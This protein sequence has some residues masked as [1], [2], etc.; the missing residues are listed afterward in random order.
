MHEEMHGQV[1]GTL[2][3]WAQYK[4][5]PW[6]AWAFWSAHI[7]YILIELLCVHV[8]LSHL[9]HTILLQR[10]ALL[11]RTCPRVGPIL[12]SPHDGSILE[13]AIAKK[14]TRLCDHR[15]FGCSDGQWHKNWINGSGEDVLCSTG[16]VAALF[17]EGAEAAGN[18]GGQPLTLRQCRRQLQCNDS[19][20]ATT[21]NGSTSPARHHWGTIVCLHRS[22]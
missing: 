6:D 18:V 20:C 3:S 8:I 10:L 5:K 17:F 13:D 2:G 12:D 15:G 7:S 16:L 14:K 9:S 19:R 11:Q 1:F 21:S 22:S 4:S